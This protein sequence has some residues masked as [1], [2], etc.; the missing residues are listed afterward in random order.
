MNQDNMNQYSMNQDTMNQAN[1]NQNRCD[2]LERFY[3]LLDALAHRTHGLRLLGRCSGGDGWPARGVY[4]F[5]EEGERRTHC[6]S[7]LRVSEILRRMPV[8]HLA[9][10]DAP[11][12]HSARGEI[13]R[14]AIALLSNVDKS[15]LDPPSQNWLGRHC[16]R[17]KVRMSGL[18]NQ[19]HVDET[20][21]AAF[22]DS[23]ERRITQSAL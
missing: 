6:G 10:D 11:S 4:F 15:P 3:D 16:Q 13:E 17:E 21:N 1:A 19:N 8:L 7:G 18:W 9:V 2:D 14:G 20:Y 23:L 22:L 12:R 5:F